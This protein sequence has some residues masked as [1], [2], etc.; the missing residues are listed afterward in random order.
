MTCNNCQYP[1]LN[2]YNKKTTI[3]CV[4][5]A[6]NYEECSNVAKYEYCWEHSCLY[7]TCQYY[8]SNS[9]NSCLSHDISNNPSHTL[10]TPNK[11]YIMDEV[12]PENN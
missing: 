11:S 9:N 8:T 1:I 3:L 10:E 12:N 5:C 2:I 6:C 7:P 4:D